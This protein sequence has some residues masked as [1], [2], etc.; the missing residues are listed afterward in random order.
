MRWTAACLYTINACWIRRHS[1]TLACCM[2][3]VEYVKV[4]HCL[5]DQFGVGWRKVVEICS[6]IWSATIFYNFV[7]F[8]QRFNAFRCYIIDCTMNFVNVRY[9]SGQIGR[10]SIL[11]Y[12]CILQ[13]HI[14]FFLNKL[15][16]DVQNIE[17][18]EIEKMCGAPSLRFSSFL[19]LH[20]C[21][22][23]YIET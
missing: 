8:L 10:I 16:K 11:W 23:I 22:A 17:V 7:A 19:K 15:S 3:R 21:H 4:D 14:E 2:S 12:Y 20:A 1:R 6:D 5:T 13:N 18:F 9:W